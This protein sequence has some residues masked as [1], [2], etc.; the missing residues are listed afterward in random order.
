LRVAG[1]FFHGEAVTDEGGIYRL[2]GLPEG[3]IFLQASAPGRS[4]SRRVD[5]FL[6]SAEPVTASLLAGGLSLSGTVVDAESAEPLEGV[7]VMAISKPPGG[8]QWEGEHAVTR[9]DGAFALTA[10]I[11]GTNE[12]GVSAWLDGY[13][14]A[15]VLFAQE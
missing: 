14:P 12:I 13:E 11:D 10:P 2:G 5:V 7:T 4:P 3:R 6:P 8:P 15:H 9:V 1:M